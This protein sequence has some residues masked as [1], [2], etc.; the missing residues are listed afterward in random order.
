MEI[1]SAQVK[2]IC[3]L[4]MPDLRP[5]GRHRAKLRPPRAGMSLQPIS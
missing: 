1:P 5:C 4:Q 3:C 2:Y